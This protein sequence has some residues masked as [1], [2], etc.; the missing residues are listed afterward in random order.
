MQ[1]GSRE[2]N[3]I[4][5][6]AILKSDASQI[7]QRKINDL[8]TLVFNNVHFVI[9][10]GDDDKIKAWQADMAASQLKMVEELQAHAFPI[11]LVIF[12][13]T[14][15]VAG[16]ANGKLAIWNIEANSQS[17]QDTEIH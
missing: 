12:N 3:V 10:C 15:I 4:S 8:A 5:E 16:L 13:G 14:M 17:Y 7:P 9:T 11:S 6:N 1:E 2:I